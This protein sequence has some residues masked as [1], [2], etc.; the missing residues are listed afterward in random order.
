M[1]T[2]SPTILGVWRNLASALAW[3]AR[4]C[5]FKSCHPDSLLTMKSLRGLKPMTTDEMIF[6]FLLFLTL[7]VVLARVLTFSVED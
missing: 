7:G 2:P 5:R 4:S 6:W 1:T 3:G